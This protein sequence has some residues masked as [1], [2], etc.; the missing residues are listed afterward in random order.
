MPN[1]F[2]IILFSLLSFKKD[3][4]TKLFAFKQPVAKARSK[5]EVYMEGD[6]QIKKTPVS[7]SYLIW[8]VSNNPS[9]T[10]IYSITINDQLIS[11]DTAHQTGII[12]I[13][14]GVKSP[15]GEGS[16]RIVQDSN[17]SYIRI[18]VKENIRTT[19]NGLES[20]SIRFKESGRCRKKI[21]KSIEI[22]PARVTE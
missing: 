8:L 14:E 19:E 18:Y 20:I 21:K 7:S 16:G 3:P 13:D 17:A 15:F 12:K 10:K 9:K 22:L 4:P 1:L 2:Y 11:F 5:P 6:L